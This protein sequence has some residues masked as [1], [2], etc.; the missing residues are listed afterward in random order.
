MSE[1][2]SL[3]VNGTK[4]DSFVDQT[5]RSVLEELKQNG[6]DSGV[7]VD[8]IRQA[9]EDYL[10]ENPAGGMSASA[11]AMLIEILRNGLYA[12]DQSESI[13][14]LN[15]ALTSGGGAVVMYSIVYDLTNAASS[16]SASGVAADGKY[17]AILTPDEGYV[18]GTVRITMGGVDVTDSVY[19][20]GRITIAVVTGDVAITAVAVI[21]AADGTVVMTDRG[22]TAFGT[23]GVYADGGE[24]IMNGVAGARRK[25]V[26]DEVFIEDTDVT[27]AV[28]YGFTNTALKQ[29]V[30]CAPADHLDNVYYV[31]EIGYAQSEEYT[32]EYVV[33]AGYRLVIINYNSGIPNLI[34]VTKRG[35][36]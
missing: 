9:V 32:Y 12:V 29:W 20:D 33:R 5:A 8:Q 34:T 19:A 16:N 24:T 31:E 27:I 17:A 6:A 13:S 23:G 4:Y 14:A 2:K 18:L 3:T 15:A 22:D 7:S 1:I 21:A 28:K 10:A 30:G 25:W 26:S 36:V 11:A 35:G